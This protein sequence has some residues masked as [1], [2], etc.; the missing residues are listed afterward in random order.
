[1]GELELEHRIHRARRAAIWVAAGTIAAGV[2]V[3]LIFRLPHLNREQVLQGA[4]LLAD[5][6]PRKQLPLPGVE[7]TADLAGMVAETRSGASGF[8]R[9]SWK[10]R[11]WRDEQVTL[12]FRHPGYQPLDVTFPF[13]EELYVAR[14]SAIDNGKAVKSPTQEVAVTGIRVRYAVKATTTVN[15]GS[16][17]KVFEV[18]NTGGVPCEGRPPCSPDGK[19]KAAVGSLSLD[20]GEGHEFRNARVSCIAGPCPFTKI[21]SDAFSRG[22]RSINATVRAWSDTVTFLAVTG[23]LPGS[24]FINQTSAFLRCLTPFT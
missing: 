10:T 6:D 24:F 18:V 11:I 21:E 20:A 5:A 14:M 17:A 16:T 19:W 15:V 2:A 3:F 8:F 4:V 12:K 1:V 13:S 22:G 9:L 23:F 7:I